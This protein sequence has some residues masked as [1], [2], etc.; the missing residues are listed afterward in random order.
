MH[1]LAIEAHQRYSVCVNGVM[2][3]QEV[4]RRCELLQYALMEQIE[5]FQGPK[6]LSGADSQILCVDAEQIKWLHT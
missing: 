1:G 3:Q 5:R 6:L 4:T 2:A